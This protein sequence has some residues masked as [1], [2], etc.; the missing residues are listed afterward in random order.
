M[1]SNI[2][3]I[4]L[5][6]SSAEVAAI[7]ANAIQLAEQNILTNNLDEVAAAAARAQA[8][9]DAAIQ[10]QSIIIAARS[11]I[12][13]S[14]PN[15]ATISADLDARIIA[16]QNIINLLPDRI[17]ALQNGLVDLDTAQIR[18]FDSQ[19][20]L[21]ILGAAGDAAG[22]AGD[23]FAAYIIVDQLLEGDNSGAAFDSLSLLASS[24]TFIAV[25]GTT[26]LSSIPIGLALAASVAAAAV[27]FAVSSLLEAFVGD[28]NYQSFIT[29]IVENA[30]ELSQVFDGFTIEDRQLEN[31]V[32]LEAGLQE[33]HQF[34]L[35]RIDSDVTTGE[36]N[37]ILAAFSRDPQKGVEPFLR[38]L[39]KLVTGTDGGSITD[40]D[41]YFNRVI[42]I[43]S[44]IG[45]N[46]I[47]T[48]HAVDIASFSLVDTAK[49]NTALG[50]ATR[51]ALLELNPF[52]LEANNPSFY[53][54][55]NNELNIQNFSDEY[56]NDRAEFLELLTSINIENVTT[57]N[58]QQFRDA[59][60]TDGSRD[61]T[62]NN[63]S[64]NI[65]DPLTNE[66]FITFGTDSADTR[67]RFS[68]RK[69]DDKIYGL[70]GND[71]L[72]GNDGN[73]TI[74]GGS[75]QDILQGG[76][77]DDIL[78]SGVGLQNGVIG[79]DS[80][81]EDKLFGGEGNDTY[82]VGNGDLIIDDQQGQGEVFF[83]GTLL[84]GGTFIS[85]SEY[86]G[87]GFTYILNGGELTVRDTSN[88][89]ITIQGYRK[90]ENGYLGITLAGDPEAGTDTTT[91][92]PVSTQE[93]TRAFGDPNTLDDDTILGTDDQNSLYGAAGND[94][95]Q[96]FANI[97]Y[98]V[99]NWGDDEIDGG[100]G[101]DW[102]VGDGFGT[103]NWSYANIIRSWEFSGTIPYDGINIIPRPDGNPHYGT[104]ISRTIAQE[105][106]ND[107]IHGGLGNDFIQANGGNDFV[108]GEDGSD[109]VNG[110]TGNDFIDGGAGNDVVYA[111][112][113]TF[114]VFP[115]QELDLSD[116]TLYG[117][118]TVY[119]GA[120]DDEIYSGLLNDFIDGGAGNDII[121]S[122]VENALG[123]S[124]DDT[125]FGGSGNDILI[126]RAGDDQLFGG[127]ND[128]E[129][130]GG[131]GNDFLD[132]GDGQDLLAGN[133]GDDELFGGN[134][135]DVL[136]GF[137]GADK[138]FGGEGDDVLIGYGNSDQA[139]T[140]DGVDELFGGAG[141][142]R[143]EAGEGNDL[144]HGN[145]G[146][147]ELAGQEGD[148]ILFGDAGD[149]FL[150]GDA[151]NDILVGGAGNDTLFDQ[152]G[153]ETYKIFAGN[154]HDSLFDASGTDTVEF[155]NGATLSSISTQFVGNNLVVSFDDNNSLILLDWKNSQFIERFIFS[156]GSS[157]SGAL[158]SQNEVF[159]SIIEG[160]ENANVLIG[161]NGNDV[162]DGKA[163]A[164]DL[165]GGTGDDT[166]IFNVGSGADTITDSFGRNVINFGTGILPADLNV[167]SDAQG[168]TIQVGTD[169][170][171]LA[172]TSF[173]NI[174]G[175]QFADGTLLTNQDIFPD[176]T[177]PT[178]N[179]ELATQSA[180]VG[181]FISIQIPDD[182]FSDESGLVTISTNAQDRGLS[183]DPN[184]GIISGTIQS[185][186]FGNTS[187]SIFGEDVAGNISRTFLPLSVNDPILLNPRSDILPEQNIAV[188]ET[189]TYV[190]PFEPTAQFDGMTRSTKVSINDGQQ[191]SLFGITDINDFNVGVT[192]FPSW[193]NYDP[194]TRTFTGTPTASD[195]GE[196]RFYIN[197]IDGNMETR[198]YYHEFDLHIRDSINAPTANERVGDQFFLINQAGS[199]TLPQNLFSDPNAGSLTL[200][201]QLKSGSALPAWLTFDSLTGE[202]AIA[203]EGTV[204]FIEIEVTATDDE[205]FTVTSDFRL[206]LV[207]D[208]D[209][210]SGAP[211]I[212]PID[213]EIAFINN[214][215]QIFLSDFIDF[216]SG[217]FPGDPGQLMRDQ[218]IISAQRVNGDSVDWI[219]TSQPSE[220]GTTSAALSLRPGAEDAGIYEIEVTAMNRAGLSASDIFTI[221][222]SDSPPPD[223]TDVNSGTDQ[224]DMI[225]LTGGENVYF[226]GDGNDNV[227]VNP[228]SIGSGIAGVSFDAIDLGAGNDTIEISTLPELFNSSLGQTD[229]FGG[230]GDD[231]Y[232]VNLNP[233]N[234]LDI[235]IY[236]VADAS[237]GNVVQ[238]GDD[239]SSQSLQLN[240]GSLVLDFR[241]GVRVRFPDFDP[242]DVF[243]SHAV[244]TFEF[245]DGTILT[246]A[247]LV[248]RGFDLTGTNNAEVIT[249]TN[250][251]DRIT[252][253]AGDDVL[254][255]GDGDD[256]YFVNT[257]DGNDVITDTSGIDRVV[258]GEDVRSTQP[259]F[260]QS[261][262]DLVINLS[263]TQTLTVKDW[264]T[265]TTN[266]IESFEFIDGTTIS[267]T[268]VGNLLG[269]N[270]SPVVDNV[271]SDQIIDQDSMFSFQIPVNTFSDPDA[272][273]QLTLSATLVDGS[274]LP[275]WLSFD[276]NTQT[277]TGT[278]G[279]NDIGVLDVKVTAT[280]L[281]EKSVSDEF[282]LTINNINDAPIVTNEL[283]V[284]FATQDEA[285]LF[286]VP[287]NTFSDPDVG[288]VLTYSSSLS[289]GSVL[290]SW[291]S[292]DAATQT[293]SGT[294]L[295]AD[296][297]SVQIRVTATDIAGSITSSEFFL[298]VFDVNEAPAVSAQISDQTATEN[299]AFSFAIP[300]NTFSDND[301]AYFLSL[302]VTLTDGSDL[303]SWLTFDTDLLALVGTPTNQDVGTLDIRV[304]ATDSRDA[305][306][307]DDFTI[308]VEASAFNNP[309]VLSNALEDQIADEDATFSFVVPADTFTDPDAGDTLSY[310]ATLSDGSALPI[311]LSF[312]ALTQTFSG[313]PENADVGNVSVRVTVTDSSNASVFDDF[314]LTVNNT[315]DAPI[316]NLSIAEQ[317][318]IEDQVF[319]YQIPAGTIT[320]PDVGDTLIY[321]ATRADG[322]PLPAWLNFDAST[323]TFSGTPAED[324]V[325][326]F[327][328]LVTATDTAGESVTVTFSLLVD[329]AGKILI[330][331]TPN[332]D[333]L[334]APDDQDYLIRARGDN[335]TLTGRGVMT[336]SMVAMVMTRWPA[337]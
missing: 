143:L 255:G 274:A 242:N 259:V 325:E 96:G 261:N 171:T 315:N 212:S 19:T 157:L 51:Y 223:N 115:G 99:G 322:S 1:S 87:G 23:V 58:G 63:T 312:D 56:I 200:S 48:I 193:L 187:V 125:I 145:E 227:T 203:A 320:D 65:G 289:N 273:D 213:D 270:L 30:F 151:G 130:Q 159:S 85:E 22:L 335:D 198:S 172:G 308:T 235:N 71:V 121:D 294:P 303:P 218:L 260:S 42:S 67:A 21:T 49:Q 50:I 138:L 217:F 9:L 31:G 94:V 117:N 286:Q 215:K 278:P 118:D 92:V 224:D 90:D 127:D 279:N 189:F 174:E 221:L 238:F 129:L 250:T 59:V 140:A 283:D 10:S 91:Q 160:D 139:T 142:D 95:L 25:A 26:A 32:V 191:V 144:L 232:I 154:G 114:F 55:F 202:F 45:D 47:G 321:S 306:V 230:E 287:E 6:Q 167:T 231:V 319:M 309:P 29:F 184:T 190:I 244:E 68:G 316:V 137:G 258:F 158:L 82:Y 272:T 292:F 70:G 135:N 327:D 248:N 104:P 149:D 302:E 11:R 74:E 332:V 237:G 205:N 263:D 170:L 182:L 168:V 323:Q 128:D 282:T 252:G 208:M 132:G 256:S 247:D 254:Q 14:L 285:F 62:I 122:G 106:G 35:A 222:V 300:F 100:D 83:N 264:F 277:F 313:T 296:V 330:L 93:V 267:A 80:D 53:S 73:D 317:M 28:E 177:P 181:D 152:Q 236:D 185:S 88:N 175:Y 268:Q 16:N 206:F 214:T 153:N 113:Q 337:D 293:F 173:Q 156:D 219:E 216:S 241:G 165:Q 148:D 239:F 179:F 234:Q 34:L 69:N 297:G 24:V 107:T 336:H 54:Q 112:N 166:Y 61:L 246:Y 207:D 108:Y 183:F 103:V 240:L 275:I 126:A 141:N 169:S 211:T 334:V 38:S 146:N 136:I 131:D 284:Q 180:M 77:G 120:G 314:T 197:A 39:E 75:G 251:V 290:P 324:D 307:F 150:Q 328:I 265:N 20:R 110:G 133:A 27:G 331:G 310:S 84:T 134:E 86:Q 15:G 226:A 72:N 295:N 204:Q 33:L 201:A 301:V 17:T 253:L 266:Q 76:Q 329:D 147:D 66:I 124:D 225:T 178:V 12:D 162:I 119:G 249:G 164:D 101:D 220:I 276:S 318:A 41:A 257:G 36:A 305:S 102:L 199:L 116:P 228:A 326:D 163:G 18:V 109:T 155:L 3:E 4:E 57:F 311:W 229:I 304:T 78:I 40:S 81:P 333:N 281:N 37:E 210:S 209:P 105:E 89:A 60:F 192:D 243:G 52:I 46:P 299:Q 196:V 195:V 245:A 13:L 98:L 123:L 186:L 161:T 288:D 43:L 8:V 233:S 2:N 271:I 64:T 298:N 269:T 97:D 79:E 262:N 5:A 280:D 291:L 176:T 44:A 111:D 188:G 7:T 194:N